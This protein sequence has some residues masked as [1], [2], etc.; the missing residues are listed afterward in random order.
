MKEA[1]EKLI[2]GYIR[3][4]VDEQPSAFPDSLID[5]LTTAK[6]LAV[7]YWDHRTAKEIERDEQAGI[8]ELEYQQWVID[9]L[10]SLK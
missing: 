5:L 7:A 8:T 10:I 2:R 4:N 9:E 1:I 3:K 6:A